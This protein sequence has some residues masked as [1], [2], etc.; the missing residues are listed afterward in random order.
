MFHDDEKMRKTKKSDLADTLEE[1]GSD[2]VVL[3]EASLISNTDA[4]LIDGMAMIRG[5]NENH[6]KTF[7][8]VGKIVL[9]RIIRILNSRNMDVD[10]VTVVF[11][12][13]EGAS[14][15]H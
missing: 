12:V 11:N 5:L 7:N 4:Y 1:N 6:F 14:C 13:Q 9:K 8:D 15:N 10:S 2:L 3:S